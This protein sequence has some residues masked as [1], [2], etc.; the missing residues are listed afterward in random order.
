MSP[1]V[2]LVHASVW[3]ALL[4]Y[5][6]G[7]LA[8]C[9]GRTDLVWQRRARAVYTFGCA[10]FLVHVASAFHVFYDW[11]HAVALRETARQTLE[12]TGVDSG[13][14]LYFNYV[15]TVLWIVDAAWW[16]IAGLERF[17]DRPMQVT[18]ALHGFFVFMAFNGT[19]VFEHGAVRWM[20]ALGTLTLVAALAVGR[21]WK[22]G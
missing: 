1:S 6:A 12:V 5:L 9:L 15:F 13:T 8:A 17:R 16:H 18:A 10:A 19:V 11:S 20:G 4:A 21:P 2:F 7:P 14:G 3:I 22:V